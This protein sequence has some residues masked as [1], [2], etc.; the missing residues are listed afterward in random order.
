MSRG[1]I[2]HDGGENAG[3]GPFRDNQRVLSFRVLGTPIPQG[4]MNAYARGG[5]VIVTHSKSHALKTWRTLIAQV[6]KTTTTRP[7]EGPVTAEILFTLPRPKAH[8]RTGRH[9]G[10]VKP[11]APIEH[12]KKPDLDKLTRAVL[13]ALT[14]SGI[15]RDDA[16]ISTLTAVKTYG[17]P[18]AEIT[19]RSNT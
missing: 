19:L 17:T 1:V 15:I 10:K 5:R 7:L 12:T 16:Q 11:T 18:G 4:S 13:D 2:T 6:A 8:Y 3:N 14:Q 9:A